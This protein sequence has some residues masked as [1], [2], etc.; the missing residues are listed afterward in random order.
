MRVSMHT[1]THSNTHIYTHTQT[2]IYNH[3]HTDTQTQI[4]TH[5][6]AST[7]KTYTDKHTHATIYMFVFQARLQ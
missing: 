2:H 7:H 5:T 1:H 6:L 4:Y 3:L